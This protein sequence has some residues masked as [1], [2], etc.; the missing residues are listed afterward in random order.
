MGGMGSGSWYR[1]DKKSTVEESLTVA[2]RDFRGKIYPHSSGAFTWTWASGNS[3]SIGYRV[4][5]RDV[6]IITLTYRWR[7]R[8]DVAIPIRLQTTPT[9]FNGRRWWFS[10]PLVRGTRCCLRRVGKLYLP[11]GAKYFGCRL[12]HDLTYESSQKAHQWERWLG[13]QERLKECF[14][15]LAIELE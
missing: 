13:R 14:G 11:P 6:P 1:F 3:A 10:C 7:D 8:E 9:N 2:M 15:G 12:C 4:T 5:W